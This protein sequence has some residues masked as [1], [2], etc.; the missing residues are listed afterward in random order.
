MKVENRG[1]LVYKDTLIFRSG[2]ILK[3]YQIVTPHTA[4]D[5]LKAMLCNPYIQM[6]SGERE[7]EHDVGFGCSADYDRYE[8]V[9]DFLA[10]GDYERY[11]G[12]DY[13]S[14]YSFFGKY[15]GMQIKVRFADKGIMTLS[16][17]EDTIDLCSIIAETE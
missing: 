2:K 14:S 8:S 7:A 15:K 1:Y 13:I 11:A 12:A 3:T 17:G 4:V 9:D 10:S 5:C 16:C 6:D